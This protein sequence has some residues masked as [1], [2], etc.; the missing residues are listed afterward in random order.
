MELTGC[1]ARF[2]PFRGWPVCILE[3]EYV[4]VVALPEVNGRFPTLRES[5]RSIWCL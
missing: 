4:C 5:H 1:H 2:E 3:N